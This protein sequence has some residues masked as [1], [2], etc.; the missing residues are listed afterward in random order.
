MKPKYFFWPSPRSRPPSAP[1]CYARGGR[2]WRRRRLIAPP[3]R[4]GRRGG[5]GGRSGPTWPGGGKR[6]PTKKRLVNF[7]HKGT[8]FKEFYQFSD[9]VLRHPYLN[10]GR[11]SA[12]KEGFFWWLEFR[13]INFVITSWW[14]SCRSPP[15]AHPGASPSRQ[16]SRLPTRSGISPMLY[17][18]MSTCL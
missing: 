5:S 4:R 3:G 17:H 10:L 1:L 12:A 9:S 6:N 16:A 15:S 13:G 2:R 8:F 11:D 7:V 18:K 14:I